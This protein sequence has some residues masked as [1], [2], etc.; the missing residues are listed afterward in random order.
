[1]NNAEISPK[2]AK[3]FGAAPLIPP[4][5]RNAEFPEESQTKSRET[6]LN[7]QECAE[8]SARPPL[9]PDG[10]SPSVIF[11]REPPFSTSEIQRKLAS[12][13]DILFYMEVKFC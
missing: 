12:G 8:I 3:N 6:P 10:F 5:K 7:P 11:R 1:M 2:R 9:I 13:T 4:E